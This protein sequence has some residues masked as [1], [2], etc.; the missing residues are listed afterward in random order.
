MIKMIVNTFLM[1]ADSSTLAHLI[2]ALKCVDVLI[3]GLQDLPGWFKTADSHNVVLD[4]LSKVLQI[5]VDD[6]RTVGH[7]GR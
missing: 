4:L 1:R 7:G 2:D 3:E 5:L 6:S